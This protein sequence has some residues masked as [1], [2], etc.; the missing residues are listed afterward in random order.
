MCRFRHPRS[1]L[2]DSYWKREEHPQSWRRSFPPGEVAQ[3]QRLPEQER[4]AATT[5]LAVRLANREVPEA[6]YGYFITPEF[7]SGRIG[8]KVFPPFGYG[9]DLA[10]MC[11]E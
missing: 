4:A 10:A 7:F 3:L 9:V 8:C 5:E 2:L 11:R 1:R 6:V